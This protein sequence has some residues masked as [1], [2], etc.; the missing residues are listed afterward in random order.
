MARQKAKRNTGRLIQALR[1][2][3]VT[4]PVNLTHWELQDLARKHQVVLAD[5]HT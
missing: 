3:G 2:A 5:T 4:V 1:R